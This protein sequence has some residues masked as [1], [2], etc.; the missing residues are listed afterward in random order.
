MLI[1]KCSWLHTNWSWIN[2]MLYYGRYTNLSGKGSYDLSNAKK[3]NSSLYTRP[4][5]IECLFVR[6]PWSRPRATALDVK[7]LQY[8]LTNMFL[9][10][11]QLPK[12]KSPLA[13]IKPKH[14]KTCCAKGLICW[15]CWIIMSWT[16]TG[17]FSNST[18]SSITTLNMIFRVKWYLMSLWYLFG[19]H[20]L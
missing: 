11:M 3:K 18:D 4:E 6:H 2:R 15:L 16:S 20:F 13:I 8:V 19:W 5:W 10:R 14:V 17:Y 9:S 12:P 1:I 7:L